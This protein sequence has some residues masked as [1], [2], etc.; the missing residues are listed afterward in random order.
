MVR[1]LYVLRCVRASDV[2]LVFAV[3]LH[4]ELEFTWGYVF[5]VGFFDF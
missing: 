1:G 5:V 2:F 4:G 3:C